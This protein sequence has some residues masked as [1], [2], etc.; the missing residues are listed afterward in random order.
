MKRFISLLF[1][2]LI[3]ILPTLIP[4]SSSGLNRKPLIKIAIIRQDWDFFDSSFSSKFST[5]LHT[6]RLNRGARKYD[7]RVRV[8]DFWDSWDGG[9]VQRGLLLRKNIDVVIAPGGVGGWHT[10]L[11]YRLQLRRFVR[12]GGGFYG[13][14]GDSTFGSLG[15]EKLSWRY[16]SLISKILGFSE[17]SPML[18]LANVYTDASALRTIIRNPRFFTMLDMVQFI[19]KLPASRGKIHFNKNTLP[20]QKPYMGENIRIMLGNAPLVNGPIVNNLFMPKVYTIASF[21]RPDDPYDEAI[22]YKKAIVAT[23]YYRGKVVLSPIHAEFTIGNLRAQDI[24]FRNV[25]WLADELEIEL[26]DN[27]RGFFFSS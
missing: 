7:V 2:I 8:Y 14:C 11:R 27:N 23:T 20:I 21:R 10:P 12:K 22:K 25:L 6:I 5:M 19:S 9:D 15:V 1:V 18:G 24:Y 16:D 17:L 13:I 4:D 3:L 26:K